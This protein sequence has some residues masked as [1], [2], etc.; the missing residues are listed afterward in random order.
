MY[1]NTF[2]PVQNLSKVSAINTGGLCWLIFFKI[3]E[4]DQWPAADP[5]TSILTSDIILKPGAIFYAC[6]LSQKT[7]SFQ[8]SSKESNA[9]PYVEMT[10][11]GTL[12]GN[13]LN[14]ITGI[15]SMQFHQYG[16]LF[17]ERNGE[18]RLIGNEDS[19][20]RLVWDYTSG[21]LENSR[22]RNMKFLWEH[23]LS[24]PIYQGANIVADGQI[25]PI[26][27]GNNQPQI[28]AGVQLLTRFKVGEVG[29]PMASGD[30]IYTNPDLTGKKVMVF[31]GPSY[32]NQKADPMQRYIIKATNNNQ[33]MF[34]GGVGYDE[35]IEIY[36]YL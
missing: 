30:T 14:L 1:L 6:D 33:I 23:P 25:I 17:K 16:L 22:L 27:N 32:L 29:S 13:N 11:S 3:E 35:I 20:A 31:A 24:A 34:V 5:E 36:T 8:E 2:L 12:A 9:G 4:V 7:R 21:T 26:G 10:V 18:Q 28:I 19:G 15:A